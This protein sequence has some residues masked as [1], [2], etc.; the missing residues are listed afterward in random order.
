MSNIFDQSPHTLSCTSVKF[1]F[2][3]AP[4]AEPEVSKKMDL[5]ISWYSWVRGL[6]ET[7][8]KMWT[9]EI[10]EIW[11][12]QKNC[13]IILLMRKI[14]QLF[15]VHYFMYLKIW[16]NILKA[17]S[18]KSIKIQ[19]FDK[20]HRILLFCQYFGF[21]YF[22]L[23]TNEKRNGFGSS[24]RLLSLMINPLFNP[25]GQI[26]LIPPSMLKD[27]FCQLIHP[28]DV[29]CHWTSDNWRQPTAILHFKWKIK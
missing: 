21:Q 5:A 19:C 3:P 15:H 2:L 25:K 16:E 18:P 7:E 4:V 29:N 27:I 1:F 8:Q 17:G 11:D 28:Q 14:K 23:F 20:F 13:R 12:T 9:F 6:E 24:F 10:V 26:V 22:V